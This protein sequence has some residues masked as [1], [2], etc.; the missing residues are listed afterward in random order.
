VSDRRLPALIVACVLSAWLGAIPVQAL[1]PHAEAA[2]VP[3]AIRWPAVA[4]PM[5][6]NLEVGDPLPRIICPAGYEAFVYAAGLS[7]PHG[8]AFSPDG[9]L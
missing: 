1:S 9:V 5:E 4:L 6:Q 2:R 3:F 7:S 8:L